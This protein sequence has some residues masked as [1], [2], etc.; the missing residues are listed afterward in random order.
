M[1][2]KH[3]LRISVVFLIIGIMTTGA[4]FAIARTNFTSACETCH[5]D[6]S[7]LSIS[8]NATGEAYT[9]R[10]TVAFVLVVDASGYSGGDDEFC[11]SLQA[12]WADNDEF[13]F[14]PTIVEDGGAGDTNPTQN[15]VQA[16]LTF[17]PKSIGSY[18]I[19]IYSASAGGLSAILDVAITVIHWDVVAPIIDSPDDK[20]VAEGD[21]LANVT[22]TPT[23]SNPDSYEVLD[24]VAVLE[25]GS[26]DGSPLEVMLDT[27]GLGTHT[28]TVT[29]WD[30]ASN[31][32]SD[33]VDA[34]VYDGTGPVIPDVLDFSIPEGDTGNFVT[35][36]P[37][38]LHPSSYEIWENET[39]LRTG[40]WNSSAEAI[41]ASIDGYSMGIVNYTI[42]VY[43]GEGASASDVVIISIVDGTPPMVDHPEDIAYL[44]D[45]PGAELTWTFSDMYPVSYEVYKE[46]SLLQSGAWNL[47][48]ESVTID[49]GGLPEGTYNFTLAIV[50]IGG[51]V[52]TDYV[53]V[54]SFSAVIPIIFV[55]PDIYMSEGA[56]GV[57]IVWK[58]IDLNPLSYTVFRDGLVI[59]NGPWNDSS[60]VITV[61]LDGLGLGVYNY[62][63][64]VVDEDIH[65]A[66]DQVWVTVSDDTPPEITPI[67]D[68]DYIE[69]DSGTYIIDWEPSDFNP[70]YYTILLNDGLYLEGNWNSSSEIFSIDV[71]QMPMGIYNYTLLV[72][73]V[74]GN[75]V[76]DT[77]LVN[78]TDQTLPF[79]NNPTEMS[80]SD[81][82]LDNGISW[83]I[84]EVNPDLYEL[85]IDDA[86]TQSGIWNSSQEIL[87][88]YLNGTTLGVYN[89]TVTVY[90]T[91]NNHAHSTILVSV[92]DDTL[93][94]VNNPPDM[95]YDDSETGNAISW[96]VY[97]THLLNYEVYRNDVRYISEDFPENATSLVIE[98][99]G[100]NVGSH[101]FTLV[102]YDASGN[103]ASDCVW[104]SVL[105]IVTDPPTTTTVTETPT[106]NTNATDYVPDDPFQ[107][108]PQ[109]TQE[110][111]A[112]ILGCIMFGAMVL[113]VFRIDSRSRR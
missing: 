44:A 31:S 10:W 106:D 13:T 14:T 75:S 102:I 86:L 93:P 41:S 1:N 72:T 107:F 95:H 99:D 85:H 25:S 7:T 77:V 26:W 69:G 15:E 81:G 105:P 40:P 104:V 11:I 36:N 66:T 55:H 112:F 92:V 84:T 62:T 111:G 58:P 22:W 60:E 19:R 4:I 49:V 27:L 16:S 82:S 71:S 63:L 21:P 78:I 57:E 101:N 43:D 5:S 108:I 39:L 48:I 2:R 103:I 35:W 33:S 28:L 24:G 20:I 30:I 12:G 59:K 97:D 68:I 53:Q 54:L 6:T 90:D 3:T 17:T 89:F 23:E 74:G 91:S 51:N 46:E 76:T 79:F 50:D 110:T 52:V 29:V 61:P 109:L 18:T 73:D 64:F 47:T 65:T 87:T 34:T 67:S 45:T 37:Y 113:I 32:V 38:D 96:D 56:T 88:V 9:A 83:S 98:V 8:S 100:L 94:I 80:I 70:E 42:V